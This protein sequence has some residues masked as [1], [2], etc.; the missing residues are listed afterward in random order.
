MLNYSFEK[1]VCN[2]AVFNE[3]RLPA[4]ADFTACRN[5]E[6][7]SSGRSGLQV[8]LDGVWHFHC[9]PR[10]AEA[11]E[12]FWRPDYDLADWDSIRVPAHI[13]LEGYDRPAYVNTQYPWDATEEL[14]PG[15]VPSVFNPVADYVRFFTLPEDFRGQEVRISFQG[16]ESGFA[17]WL[18]GTYLGYSEDSF[19]PA[20]FRLTDALCEGENRLAV[21]VFKWT[22]GS[23]FED[24][25]FFRFSGIF[26]SV[27]VYM[28]PEAAVTDLSHTQ[29]R[30]VVLRR[31]DDN[32]VLRNKFAQDIL[33][34]GAVLQ[35]QYISV[36][37]DHAAV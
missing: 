11:P 17:L 14:K 28:L 18:N 24:Q 29:N 13:Q 9:S 3:G 1:T 32:V 33:M 20:D 12:G 35:G 5:E 25:D 23:W 34:P 27:F 4:H 8:P 16:V 21:R 10:P 30:S 15:E 2:P 37:P 26:R 36:L 7:L 6:E 22:P 31:T 19:S